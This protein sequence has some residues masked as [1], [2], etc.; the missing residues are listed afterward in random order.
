M[1]R[2]T[3]TLLIL[4]ILILLIISLYLWNSH[5]N[6]KIVNLT[7]QTQT[8]QQQVTKNE[9]AIHTTRKTNDI[10]IKQTVKKSLD[11]LPASNDVD[12]LVTLANDLIRTGREN[13]QRN[14]Q[15]VSE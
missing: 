15:D 6:P 8:K 2:S 14:S 5:K 3:H 12:A 13:R 7:Q 9:T 1:T 4:S 10:K 11:T